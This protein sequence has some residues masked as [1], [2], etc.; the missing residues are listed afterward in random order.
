MNA[1]F[2]TFLCSGVHPS[3]DQTLLLFIIF[4]FRGRMGNMRGWGGPLPYPSW[5]KAQLSLQHK[6]LTRMRSFGMKPVL[7][8][9]AGH[10]PYAVKALYPKANIVR[11]G[12]WGNFNSTYC[13]TYFLDPTDPLF[14]VCFSL[15]FLWQLQCSLNGTCYACKLMMH[16]DLEVNIHIQRL[17]A[18]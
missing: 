6:I 4:F 16:L 11:L 13:C 7:P 14:Q 8:G 1:S 17:R 2:S 15:C 10:I 18:A 12:D 3:G 9:F 5:Y